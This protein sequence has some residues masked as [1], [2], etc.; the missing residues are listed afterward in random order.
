MSKQHEALA[1]ADGNDN[2]AL[3]WLENS[4]PHKFRKNTAALIRRQHA[5]IV[6]MQEALTIVRNHSSVSFHQIELIDGPLTAAN[7]YLKE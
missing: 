1:L 4:K 6:Q 3:A 7:D 2:A 5:L